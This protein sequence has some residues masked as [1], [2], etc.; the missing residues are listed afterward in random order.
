MV[1]FLLFLLSTLD[2]E[3]V[4]Q[5]PNLERRAELALENANAAIDRAKQHASDAKFEKLHLA[6]IEK[7]AN[8]LDEINDEIVT[9]IFTKRK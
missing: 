7:V 9:G 3:T 4:R 8:R 1:L 2:L 5:E 6:V